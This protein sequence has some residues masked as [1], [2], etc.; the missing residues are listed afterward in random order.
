VFSD[1]IG[2]PYALGGVGH[3]AGAHGPNEY[4]MLDDVVPF[5]K[6]VVSFLFRFGGAGRRQASGVGSPQAR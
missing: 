5:M 6:S 1:V 3:G 4:I 2:I